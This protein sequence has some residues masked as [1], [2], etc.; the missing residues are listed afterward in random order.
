LKNLREL[1]RKAR[2]PLRDVVTPG[3]ESQLVGGGTVTAQEK[4]P[5]NSPYHRTRFTW[6][7]QQHRTFNPVTRR[8]LRNKY[9]LP[10]G[11]TERRVG[12]SRRGVELAGVPGNM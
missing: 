2:K 3:V 8:D 10:G 9:L 11:L 1:K 12:L 4:N 7:D 5:S 6:R